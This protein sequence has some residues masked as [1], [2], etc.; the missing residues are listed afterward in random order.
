MNQEKIG[1]FIF[2]LRKENNMTQQELAEKLKVTDRAISNW[3]NG[4]NMP[5]LSLFKSICDVFKI[6]INELL[7]GEKLQEKEYQEKLEEN[8]I[9][10]VIIEKNKIKSRKKIFLS[11]LF[12]IISIIGVLFLCLFIIDKKRMS[13]GKMIVFSTWG[14]KEY[15]ARYEFDKREMEKYIKMYFLSNMEKEYT[16]YEGATFNLANFAVAHIFDYN[17]KNENEIIVYAWVKYGSRKDNYIEEFY[18]NDISRPYIF[19]FKKNGEY[20]IKSVQGPDNKTGIDY[21]DAYLFVKK[22][23]PKNIFKIYDKYD[24]TELDQEYS[25][26]IE[27]YDY[28]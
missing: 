16:N 17:V 22:N 11:S 4:K 3:E 25:N 18:I 1:K 7:S 19:I 14:N 2:N 10:T 28:Q 6:S 24:M 5:D 26:L 8:F 23:F 12:I 27:I 9:N 15:W 21:I 20:E 13:E